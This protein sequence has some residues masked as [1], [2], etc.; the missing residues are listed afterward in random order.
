M[1]PFFP[2]D[3]LLISFFL[4]GMGHNF[5]F[6]ACLLIFLLKTRTFWISWYGN[7]VSRF[8]LLLRVHCC[9]F[10]CFVLLIVTFQT[11]LK[12]ILCYICS[13]K[14]LLL[15][16]V[17]AHVWTKVI[18]IPRTKRE[19]KKDK[20]KTS[21]GLC[22]LALWWAFSRKL[23]QAIYNLALAFTWRW[24]WTKDQGE[25]K[26]QGPI[27]SF[28]RKHLPGYSHL[29][30][31]WAIL[32]PLHFWWCCQRHSKPYFTSLLPERGSTFSSL[33]SI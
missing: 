15:K 6:F 28:L 19:W 31:S 5:F 4:T 13:L 21:P 29:A 33:P 3:S 12:D 32:F 8:F 2:K 22:R 26:A 30:S 23:G 20:E 7:F 11:I 24:C 18:W 9:F 14:S 16:L 17:S 25:I 27:V 10:V 1:F